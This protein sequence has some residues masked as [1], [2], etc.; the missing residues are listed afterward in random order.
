[1]KVG[2]TLLLGLFFYSSFAQRG[3]LPPPIYLRDV[4]SSPFQSKP[5]A[6]IQGT[7]FLE[8]KWT[9]VRLKVEGHKEV[10]DSFHVKINVYNNKIHFMSEKGVEMETTLKVEEIRIIDSSSA[11]YNKIFLSNFEQEAGFFEVVEDGGKL[12]MLK[13][14]RA[15]LWESKPL[16]LEPQKRFA[17]DEELYFSSGRVLYKANKSCT[18][19][20]DTFGSDKKILDYISSNNIKCNKEEDMKKLVVF[21]GS[22]K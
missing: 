6:G 5:H 16:G 4:F 12:K 8:D 9:L 3:I 19:I 1:M 2:I 10:I 17:P 20:K 18:F 21:V 13:K 15:L 11:F 7:C 22:L 14:H